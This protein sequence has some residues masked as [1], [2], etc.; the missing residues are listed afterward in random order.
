M[1]FPIVVAEIIKAVPH[2]GMRDGGKYS[3]KLDKW[4]GV[5]WLAGNPVLSVVHADK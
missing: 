5:A 2:L 3:I 4:I 1:R